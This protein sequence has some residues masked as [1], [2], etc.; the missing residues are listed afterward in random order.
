M[1]RED[2]RVPGGVPK[3]RTIE[4]APKRNARPGERSERKPAGTP[5][6]PPPGKVKPSILSTIK[7]KPK[8]GSNKR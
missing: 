2:R 4:V 6:M 8:A 1:V 5:S 7:A 3:G